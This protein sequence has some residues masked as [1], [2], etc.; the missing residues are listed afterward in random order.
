MVTRFALLKELSTI[1]TDDVIVLT[2][3]GKLYAVDNPPAAK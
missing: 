2:E 1:I 3:D